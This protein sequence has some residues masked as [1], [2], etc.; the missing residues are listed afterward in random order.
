MRLLD[1]AFRIGKHEPH[2]IA[3]D[4]QHGPQ[5]SKTVVSCANSNRSTISP[6]ISVIGPVPGCALWGSRLINS[7][8][9]CCGRAGFERFLANQAIPTSDLSVGGFEAANEIHLLDFRS[10]CGGAA[11]MVDPGS[12]H[13]TSDCQN[14]T[15]MSRVLKNL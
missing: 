10:M 1:I 11:R 3:A 2:L 15:P 12:G 8:D 6:P 9:Q 14:S 13:K 5:L 7:G 4:D